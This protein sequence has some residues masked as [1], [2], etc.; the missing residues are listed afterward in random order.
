MTV[1][2]YFSVEI[3]VYIDILV[4]DLRGFI[5]YQKASCKVSGCFISAA[6][7]LASL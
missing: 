1:T 5:L 3:P 4:V 7:L 6:V 2:F